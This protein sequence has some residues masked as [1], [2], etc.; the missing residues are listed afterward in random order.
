M[1]RLIE[2]SPRKLDTE[3]E[4]FNARWAQKDKN[5]MDLQGNKKGY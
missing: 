4:N 1:E 5:S 2:S 3:K